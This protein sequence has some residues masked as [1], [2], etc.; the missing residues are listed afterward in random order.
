MCITAC[1][2]IGIDLWNDLGLRLDADSLR[3]AIIS[4]AVNYMDARSREIKQGITAD[5]ANNVVISN[6][7]YK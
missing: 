5:Q 2:K 3:K 7:D 1:I 6:N 4:H